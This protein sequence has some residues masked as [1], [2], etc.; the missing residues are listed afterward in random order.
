MSTTH[1]FHF[2][3]GG[4]PA[5]S[6]RFERAKP[7]HFFQTEHAPSYRVGSAEDWMGR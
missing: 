5:E 4:G 1:L 6:L 3:S 7:Q 2:V